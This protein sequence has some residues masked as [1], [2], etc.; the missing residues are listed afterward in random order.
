[1]DRPDSLA[2]RSAG[3]PDECEAFRRLDGPPITHGDL[4]VARA[5]GPLRRLAGGSVAVWMTDDLATSVAIALLDGVASR[6]LLLPAGSTA[7]ERRRHLATA[8]VT[9][10]IADRPNVAADEGASEII[11][12]RDV[13]ELLAPAATAGARPSGA[14]PTEWLIPTSG[15]TGEPKVVAHSV[16]SLTRT[17]KARPTGHVWGLSYGV[18]RFAGLQVLLHTLL[19]GDPLIVMRPGLDVAQRIDTLVRLGCTALSA[20]PSLWR[21]ILMS[22]GA[23]A[24]T[25][26]QITLGGEIADDAILGA[27]ARR[28]PD[29]RITHIYGSTETGIGFS[30]QDGR[31]GFPASW[32]PE[33]PNGVGLAVSEQGILRVRPIGADQRMLDG[34]RL[35]EADGFI[36]TGDRVR[37]DGDRY[38][39]LG[40]DNGAINVGGNKVQPEEVERVLLT[41]PG[42][43][44]ASV[45]GRPSPIMGMVVEAL[46]VQ[47]PSLP[48]DLGR[49]MEIADFCRERLPAHG[50]P[51]I[52]RIVESIELTEAG[53]TARTVKATA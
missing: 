52:V 44:L 1:M 45:R 43:R 18:T 37:R 48:T 4:R 41:C 10:I 35:V 32:L 30:V 11:A 2:T 46:V 15:T 31:A 17:I 20:T 21:R 13:V 6:M 26:R 40:R 19:S 34:T 3:L 39:F 23:D 28:W 50:V 25:V 36:D 22:P 38:L 47:D 14:G 53:K 9:V 8:S 27:L 7:D 24:L 16:A 42:V 49:R 29:A 12:I 5:S 51:T 33:A